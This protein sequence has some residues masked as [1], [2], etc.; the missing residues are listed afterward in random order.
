MII[1]LWPGRE[2]IANNISK[3]IEVRITSNQGKEQN[4]MRDYNKGNLLLI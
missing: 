1:C 3:L 2:K 4:S